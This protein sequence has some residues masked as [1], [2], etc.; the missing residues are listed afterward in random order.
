MW[1]LCGECKFGFGFLMLEIYFDTCIERSS[2]FWCSSVNV[3]LLFSIGV[4]GGL[5]KM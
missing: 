5:K 4:Q 2:N 3:C 1:D